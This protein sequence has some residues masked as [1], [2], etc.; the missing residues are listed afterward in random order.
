[1]RKTVW[2]EQFKHVDTRS[3]TKRA[4]SLV[5]LQHPAL[6]PP[7]MK[8]SSRRQGPPAGPHRSQLLSEMQKALVTL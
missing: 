7:E 1:M 2:T 5:G 8:L 4:V 6:M 3:T